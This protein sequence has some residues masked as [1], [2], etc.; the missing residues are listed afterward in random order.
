MFKKKK[1]ISRYTDYTR[2][3]V[4]FY[5]WPTQ[6]DIF[7]KMYDQKR[8]PLSRLSLGPKGI[9]LCGHNFRN[10]IPWAPPYDFI[11]S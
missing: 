11:E 2:V 1:I 9:Q 4:Y 5:D 8:I 3:Q 7:S 6:I 10:Q